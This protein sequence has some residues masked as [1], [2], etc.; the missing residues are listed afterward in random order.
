MKTKEKLLILGRSDGT[1]EALDYAK[2][3][4][5]YTVLTD[6]LPPEEN[7]LKKQRMNTG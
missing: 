6:Y 3:T 7:T 1:K 5:L 4:G 2:E